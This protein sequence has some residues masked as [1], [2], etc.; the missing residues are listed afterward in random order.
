[1]RRA[2]RSIY[3]NKNQIAGV[4]GSRVNRMNESIASKNE[5]GSAALPRHR[6]ES[7][8]HHNYTTKNKLLLRV[9]HRTGKNAPTYGS[10]PV[11]PR[12]PQVITDTMQR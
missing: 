10:V 2:A 9:F 3:L 12:S 11:R 6:A 1:M 7:S 4:P 5:I 8:K